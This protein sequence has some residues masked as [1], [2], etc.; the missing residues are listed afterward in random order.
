M[1]FFFTFV[2]PCIVT[3]FFIIRPTRCT[4]FTSLFC[5]E[6]LHVSESASVHHQEFIHCTLST[7]MCH[8]GTVHTAFKQDQGGTEF[9][10]GPARHLSTNLYDIPFLSVQW[11]EKESISVFKLQKRVV[12]TMSGVGKST[13]CRQLF[14]NCKILIITSLYILEVLCFIKRERT[15]VQKMSRYMITIQEEI[16]IYILTFWHRKLTFKF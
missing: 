8:T 7:G 11:I 14:K 16:W 9:H 2:W 4:N 1:K 5:H 6:T 15:A 12:R 13:S 3:D 10:P